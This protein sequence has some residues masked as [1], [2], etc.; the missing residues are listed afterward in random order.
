MQSINNK[1]NK[2]IE[3]KFIFKSTIDN[4][5][6]DH[7]QMCN[8]IIYYNK[9]WNKILQLIILSLIPF[10]LICLHQ[11]FFEELPKQTIISAST[12]LL[13]TLFY[14]LLLS[15]ITAS[16]HKEVLKSYKLFNKLFIKLRKNGIIR[17]KIKVSIK[18]TIYFSLFSLKSPL[19]Y[20]VVLLSYSNFN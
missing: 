17:I 16:V 18:K 11:I 10:N 12:V 9:F 20:I 4:L 15:T 1:L 8:T 6:E 14:L 3:E 13:F 5:L 7:I 2:I 19:M